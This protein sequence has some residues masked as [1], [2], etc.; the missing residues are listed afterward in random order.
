M[1]KASG[2]GIAQRKPVSAR[3]IEGCRPA[4]VLT[5]GATPS[6]TRRPVGKCRSA[7]STSR[8]T[9]SGARYISSPSASTSAGR[10][11]GISSHH[12]SSVTDEP[13]V[14]TPSIGP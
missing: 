11:A 4:I 13:T 8:S 12:A 5:H 2:A 6:K 9:S 1:A 7:R 10:S 14:R 3:R